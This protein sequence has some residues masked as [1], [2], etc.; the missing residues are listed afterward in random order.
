MP[1]KTFKPKSL[2]DLREDAKYR[3]SNTK[4]MRNAQLSGDKEL[5]Q[6]YQANALAGNRKGS[7]TSG[8]SLSRS[9]SAKRYPSRRSI[10]IKSITGKK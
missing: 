7:L 6:V 8:T 4:L 1:T 2:E 10:V 3:E 5:A 9:Q